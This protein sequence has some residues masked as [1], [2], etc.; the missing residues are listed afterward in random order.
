MTEAKT[1]LVAGA[2]G[3][4]GSAVV[5]ALLA[6]GV[7]VRALTRKPGASLPAGAEAALGDLDDPASLR[8][9]LAGVR[10]LF[11]LAGYRNVEATLALARAAGVERV[12]L[13]SSSAAPSGDLDNAIARYHILTERAIEASGLA[14]TFVRPNAFMSNAYR[15]KPQ[16][17]AGDVVRLPFAA[18]RAACIDPDDLGA[19]IAAAFASPAHAGRAYRVSGPESLLPA[20]QVRILGEALG[21]PL[22]FEAQSDAEARADMSARMPREYVDALFKFYADG[23]LD[24][25]QVLPTVEQITGRKPGTFAAWARAHAGAFG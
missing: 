18:V 3:N 1:I 13:L 11:L 2:T 12:V 14:W 23:D 15:W 17:A 10:G 20:E 19:V 22:R 25:L 6:A 7:P 21:R 16:L 9:P 24:E 5:R 4:A 8:A